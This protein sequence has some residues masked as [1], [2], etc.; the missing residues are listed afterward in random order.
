VTGTHFISTMPIRELVA[1]FDPQLPKAVRQAAEQ[2]KYRDFLTIAVV[3][4]REQVFPDNWIYIHDP[5]VQ[6]GRIQN[7]KNWSS[8]MIANPHTTCLG[9]E[10]FCFEGDSLWSSSDEQLIELARRELVLLGMCEPE[11][12]L[13][14]TVVR[15]SKAYPVYDDLYKQHLVVIRDYLSEHLPNLQLVG[16]NGMHHYNNQDHSMMT[17]LIAARNIALNAGLDPWKVNTDAEYHEEAR[18]DEEDRSGR[19]VPMPIPASG[20]S[21]G[22][23]V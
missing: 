8:Q 11:E 21:H 22:R 12:V 6:V 16:R 4:N 15:Q 2:L 18:P 20:R 19:L 17:A 10:Y 14:G 3:I 13:W 5:T 23:S 9:M 7:F 1:S